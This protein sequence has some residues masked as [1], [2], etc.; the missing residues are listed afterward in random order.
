MWDCF[1]RLIL[2]SCVLGFPLK[3][4]LSF[5]NKTLEH[6]NLQLWVKILI[7]QERSIMVCPTNMGIIQFS[8]VGQFY[9]YFT[10]ML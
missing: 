5:Q 10:N 8:N 6:G 7:F 9:S 1:F 2:W 4:P 3:V